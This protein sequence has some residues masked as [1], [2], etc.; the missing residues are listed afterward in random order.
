MAHATSRHGAQE[1]L[2]QSLPRAN[3]PVT[4]IAQFRCPTW[5][6]MCLTRG[7]GRAGRGRAILV[8]SCHSVAS[9]NRKPDEIGADAMA[10][11]GYD[12]HERVRFWKCGEWNSSGR[13]QPPSSCLTHPSHVPS[14]R[15]AR[16][17]DAESSRKKFNRTSLAASM[18]PSWV[19][20]RERGE[21][22]EQ[23]YEKLPA[24][25]APIGTNGGMKKM[26]P[27]N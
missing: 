19:R 17:L 3:Q 6:T 12:P 26:V 1:V 23:I 8:C 2:R 4:W 13:A 24:F 27:S 18:N 21:S 9:T 11:A 15:T 7:Y 25:A 5:I 22:E 20:S 14:H 16:R 10:R